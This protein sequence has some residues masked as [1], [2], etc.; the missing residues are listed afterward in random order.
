MAQG[1]LDR[2]EQLPRVERFVQESNGPFVE[3]SPPNLII[4]MGRNKD[5]GQLRAQGSDAAL[6]F[7]SAHS[8]HPDIGDQTGRV[9][10]RTR[11]QE[12]LRGSEIASFEETSTER[13]E[14]EF[15]LVEPRTVLGREMKDVGAIRVRQESASLHAGAVIGSGK[16]AELVALAGEGAAAPIQAVLV[17]HDITPSQARNLEKAT[18]VEVLDRTAV[19]LEIF[20]TE[21][22][23]TEV[24]RSASAKR[25][26]VGRIRNKA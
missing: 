9:E 11:P 17:D 22:V 3:C 24:V 15:D 4:V 18:D 20:T 6:E 12:L 1:Y 26:T 16:L 25:R 10:N 21:G 8:R 14:P 7:N 13:A 19:L 23:G 2:S 5:D